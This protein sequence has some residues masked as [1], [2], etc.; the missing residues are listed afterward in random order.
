V[1][2][3]APGTSGTS[4]ETPTTPTQP[5]D[6]RAPWP[7]MAQGPTHQ[8]RNASASTAQGNHRSWELPLGEVL[9]GSCIIAADGTVYAATQHALHAVS[10]AGIEIWTVPVDLPAQEPPSPAVGPDGTVYLRN[11]TALDAFGPGGAL[12]WE[13]QFPHGTLSSP[14]I[15]A[16]GTIYVSEHDGALTALSP[17]GSVDATLGSGGVE[18]RYSTPAIA[19]D[20]SLTFMQVDTFGTEVWSFGP[21]GA[22]RFDAKD[23]GPV[24]GYQAYPAAGA[25]GSI[26]LA[27]DGKVVALSSTGARL[28]DYLIASN[29]AGPAVAADGTLYLPSAP[30]TALHPDGTLAWDH[31]GGQGV[32]AGSVGVAADG[33]VYAVGDRLYVLEAKGAL[34]R[35][36]DVGSPVSSKLAIDD[37]GTAFFGA[38]DGKLYAR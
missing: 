26:Y 21:D 12:Q 38:E 18:G 32:Y 17:D 37:D 28:W 30:V 36:V 34:V 23:V 29:N 16:D 25:D 2:D 31:A 3:A 22:L 24:Y 9:Y 27:A 14:T 15:A 8:S 33:S 1:V 11:G 13:A 20:G 6:A 5:S 4:G 10:P 7:M 35:V 19:G